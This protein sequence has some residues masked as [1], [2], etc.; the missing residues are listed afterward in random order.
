MRIRQEIYWTNSNQLGGPH[1]RSHSSVVLDVD[2][3]IHST[4]GTL[5]IC[6]TKSAL[7]DKIAQSRQLA[8][9]ATQVV[10]EKMEDTAT[11]RLAR[12]AIKLNRKLSSGRLVQAMVMQECYRSNTPRDEDVCCP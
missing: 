5:V 6:T 11:D 3:G 9:N 4:G 10:H 7:N 1:S 8:S 2:Q 12:A